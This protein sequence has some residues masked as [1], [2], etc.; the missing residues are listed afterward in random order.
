MTNEAIVYMEDSENVTYQTVI[1]GILKSDMDMMTYRLKELRAN[2]ARATIELKKVNV[3]PML[4]LK[5]VEDEKMEED[6]RK[7]KGKLAY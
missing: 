3:P 5:S 4:L 6:L 2:L 7:M 1:F